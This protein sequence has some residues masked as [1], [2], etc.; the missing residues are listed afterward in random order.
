MLKLFTILSAVVLT[1][2]LGAEAHLSVTKGGNK[3]GYGG[4]H[5]GIFR[6][7]KP[8]SDFIIHTELK[9]PVFNAK[10]PLGRE[11]WFGILLEDD[12]QHTRYSA[13]LFNPDWGNAPKELAPTIIAYEKNGNMVRVSADG[14]TALNGSIELTVTFSDHKLLFVA[15]SESGEYRVERE[16]PAGFQPT[17]VGLTV[18]SYH[19]P[20]TGSIL[21]RTFSITQGGA[22]EEIPLDATGGW[23]SDARTL[24]K[25]SESGAAVP[26]ESIPPQK[27]M[28]VREADI[29]VDSTVD[30]TARLQALLD[31]TS[32]FLYFPAG[33]YPIGALRIPAGSTLEFAPGAIWQAIGEDSAEICGDGVTLVGVNF[34]L[35]LSGRSSIVNAEKCNN[36]RFLNCSTTTWRGTERKRE[37]FPKGGTSLFRLKECR[38][39]EI[40]GGRF[41]DLGHVASMAYCARVTVRDNK[42]ERCGTITSFANGSESLFHYGNWSINVRFQCVWWGGDSNDTKKDITSNSARIVERGSRPDDPGFDRDTAGVYD[43]LVA[44]NIAEYGTTLA[45]GSK[46]RNV[47]VSGNYARYMDDMAYDTEGGENVVIANN[48][49]INSKCAGIGCYFYGER[50]LITGNQ[51]L[52]FDEGDEEYRGNFIRLHSP[53]KANHFGNGQIMVSNNQFSAETATPRTCSVEAAR[54]VYFLNNTFTNGGI[55]SN[56]AAEEITIAGNVFEDIRARESAAIRLR[57]GVRHIVKD[58]L[59]RISAGSDIAAIW[60]D[61]DKVLEHNNLFI[62]WKSGVAPVPTEK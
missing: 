52:V 11:S 29:P 33:N 16:V 31:Q 18:D 6:S 15:K 40:S 14:K 1:L 62:G 4:G 26:V 54:K 61:K 8:S 5:A 32:R 45:W 36:L 51:V 3:W 59:F 30:L 21:F 55:S 19:A 35:P 49:S 46:G 44:N 34:A 2:T 48:I 42:A 47:V 25:F 43:I 23:R 10:N 12:K 9:A 60:G 22:T 24:V 56:S 37:P 39:V 17:R 53:G 38:D 13:V 50:V 57:G 28:D 7:L 20:A 58:N 41:A 27:R